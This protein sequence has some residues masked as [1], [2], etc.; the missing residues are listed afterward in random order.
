MRSIIIQPTSRCMF[1]CPGCYNVRTRDIDIF[2][3]LISFIRRENE[4]DGIKK[5]TISGGDP[6]L[7]PKIQSLVDVLYE[8]G[9]TINLDTVGIPFIN[10]FSKEEAQA[11]LSKISIIGIPLD[12]IND[13]TVSFFRPDL[14]FEKSMEILSALGGYGAKVCIN[15]V[16]HHMNTAI[17]NK[18]SRLVNNLKFVKLWQIFQYMPIGDQKPNTIDRLSLT[19]DDFPILSDAL[20]HF[21]FRS[22]LEVNFKDMK[23]RS[24]QYVIICSD[25]HIRIPEKLDY[26]GH[27]NEPRLLTDI[28]M[29]YQ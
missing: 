5:I 25:G 24:N 13:E 7:Y 1:S 18:L 20:S 9:I 23:N 4:F 15:T 29:G 22:D 26:L 27:I 16:I 3:D 8:L 11:L 2:S 17:I 21:Q 10:M 28:L 14:S 6:L 19:E 12:G